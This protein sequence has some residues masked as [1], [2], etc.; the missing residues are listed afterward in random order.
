MLKQC[1]NSYCKNKAAKGRNYCHGCTKRK[2]AKRNPLRYAYNNLKSNAKRRNKY[3]DLT[4]EEFKKFAIETDYLYGK[5]KTKSSY[6][7]DRIDEDGGYTLKNIQVL[8]NENNIRKYLEWKYNDEKKKM[9]FMTVISKV[10]SKDE[11]K[12]P[13]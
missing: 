2:W 4:F 13:F 10:S 9:E 5:G 8:T 6:T 1:K 11:N 3:F 12:T 7:I